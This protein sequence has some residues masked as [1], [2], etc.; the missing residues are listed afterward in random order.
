[1]AKSLELRAVKFRDRRTAVCRSSVEGLGCSKILRLQKFSFEFRT[2]SVATPAV[3]KS[4][5]FVVQNLTIY[6]EKH[7]NDRPHYIICNLGGCCNTWKQSL[8]LVTSGKSVLPS[9][10]H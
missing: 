3:E 2:L 9:M 6:L 5:I 4:V 1:M 7:F 8:D 10:I